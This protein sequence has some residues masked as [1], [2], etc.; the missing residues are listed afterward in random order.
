LQNAPAD[1]QKKTPKPKPRALPED[2]TVVKD[3]WEGFIQRFDNPAMVMLKGAHVAA[4]DNDVMYIV[5]ADPVSGDIMAKRLDE[6]KE[7][8]GAQFGKDYNLECISAEQYARKHALIY[9]EPDTDEALLK[10]L[11][12][13]INFKMDIS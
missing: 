11:T 2:F 8:L 5:F 3:N 1:T 12:D 9:G 10:Q 4:L 13:G 6:I 7:A